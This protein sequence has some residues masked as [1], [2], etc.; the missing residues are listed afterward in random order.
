MVPYIPSKG[1]QQSIIAFLR[2]CTAQT[3]NQWDV[4]GRFRDIDLAY[5][6]EVDWTEE[7]ARAK[8]ANRAGNPNKFQNI[9]IPVVLPQ[10]E[11]AVTY[12]QS[13]FLSGIPIFGVVSDPEFADEALMMETLIA[14]QQVKGKWIQELTKTLRR[15]FKYNISATEVSWDEKTSYALETDVSAGQSNNMA[16]QKQVI[17]A[18]NFVKSLDMYN[19]IWDTR[20]APSEVAEYGEFAGYTECYSRMRLKQLIASLP[21]SHNVTS[22]FESTRKAGGDTYYGY[23]HIPMLNPDALLDRSWTQEM[24]WLSW[25][26]QDAVDRNIKYQNAY[27][28]TVLY[29]R[30]LPSDF[31]LKNVPAPNTP[32]VW[33]FIIVN[34]EVVIYSER[35]T[36][37][38]NLIPIVFNQPLDDGLNYQ[39]KSF[40]QNVQPIQEIATAFSNSSIASR[41]RAISDRMLY[42]PSRVSAGAINNDSPTAKIPVRPS[43]YGKNLAEAVYP[44]PFRDDQFQINSA[45]MQ[46]YLGMA[47]QISGLNPAR[48][49][50]FVKGNKTKAEYQDVMANANG[51]DQNIA[52]GLEDTLFSPLKEIIKSNI[53]Q[54][55]SGVRLFSPTA[56]SAVDIDPIR[57]RQANLI[58]KVSDGLAPSEK[59]IDADSLALALNTVAQSPQ[60]GAGFNLPQLFSY[61]MK[62]R[63]ANIASF[64]KSPEQQAYEQAMAQWTQAVQGFAQ[65]LAKMDPAQAQ[66]LL[67]SFMKGNPQPQPQQFNYVPGQA[68]LSST[69]PLAEKSVLSSVGEKIQNM[70]QGSE[71]STSPQAPGAQE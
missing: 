54:Y 42:D 7:Q 52:I 26:G 43:A 34:H 6:R 10:I 71:A 36:N 5:M 40:A 38:H 55:Q 13:V 24:N 31:N 60:L 12:Q 28:V 51:R 49:G 46:M 57:L 66:A 32:Q 9:V 16:K 50:Q 44:F 11:N 25:A 35:L 3:R 56:Q 58:F 21:T 68:K 61:L 59:I 62:S 67:E 1:S 27:D 30:I 65:N 22:A 20:V 48:Q 53:L 4:R 23:Y 69:S 2:E 18:G 29:G 19:V 37:A 17:W 15:G 41:R 63:G 45:E 8:M 14:Q 70:T 64:E 47:N 33:K 39:T